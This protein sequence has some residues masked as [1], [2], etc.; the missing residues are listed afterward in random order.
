MSKVIIA[1]CE[2][3][4][5]SVCYLSQR[6]FKTSKGVVHLLNGK[7]IDPISAR[8]YEIE[9][10]PGFVLPPNF[11]TRIGV[12]EYLDALGIS[13]NHVSYFKVL[14]KLSDGL[15]LGEN[16]YSRPEHT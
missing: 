11:N 3:G 13:R 16:V 5:D 10:D 9:F 12:S 15:P 7:V 2:D 1:N 14:A 8:G 6:K 4:K